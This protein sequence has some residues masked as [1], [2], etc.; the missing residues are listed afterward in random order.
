MSTDN[1]GS[2][3]R[4]AGIITAKQL[5]AQGLSRDQIAARVNRGELIRLRRGVYA[6][7]AGR[8]KYAGFVGGEQLLPAIAALAAVGPDAVVSHQSAARLYGID[9]LGKNLRQTT[10]TCLPRH[11]WRGQSGIRVHATQLPAGHVS[12]ENG[13][14]MTTP[15][16]TVIDLAREL[17]FGDG[18]VAADS[19]LYR[20]LTTKDELVEVLGACRQWPGITRAAAVVAFAD[21]RAESPLESIARAV[22]HEVGLPPPELQIW[23]G[24]PAPIARVD[25]YWK[26]FRT[27]AE[28][29]GVMK[30]DL[31]PARARQQLER[32]RLLRDADYEVLHFGWDHINRRREYIAAAAWQAFQRGQLIITER[33]ARASRP[34]RRTASPRETQL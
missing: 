24:G 28:V 33:Q 25:F 27:I 6:E 8:H 34:D 5:I 19:A 3:A 10:I 20:K 9:L 13:F 11:G 2:I 32:D 23:L 30:Y 29:D 4:F 22:F 7:P 1:F 21:R 31:D 26:Q 16:R 12:T 18:V 15:A 17:A 14:A